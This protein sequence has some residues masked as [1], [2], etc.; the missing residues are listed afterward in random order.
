MI[1]LRYKHC[2]LGIYNSLIS[3]TQIAESSVFGWIETLPKSAQT[4]PGP[5]TL[6]GYGNPGP[7]PR[8]NKG[9][10]HSLGSTSA[11][12]DA[13]QDNAQKE[14][15]YHPYHLTSMY[16]RMYINISM[17]VTDVYICHY[18]HMYR[19]HMWLPLIRKGARRLP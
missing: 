11:D 17:H 8:A 18:R 16:I 12:I 4:L 15:S 2:P 6:R 1:G 5:S 9:N 7:T 19:H 14:H 10:D 13:T 3:S